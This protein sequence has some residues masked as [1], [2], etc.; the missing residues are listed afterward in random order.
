VLGATLAFIAKDTWSLRF[1]SEVGMRDAEGAR[2]GSFDGIREGSAVGSRVGDVVGSRE[3]T[4]VGNNVGTFDG[5]FDE[6]WWS[7]LMGRCSSL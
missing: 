7:W 1:A 5:C 3:G 6:H 4:A 2:V